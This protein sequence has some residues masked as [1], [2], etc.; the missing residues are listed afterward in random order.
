MIDHHAIH[1]AVRAHVLQTVVAT[2]TTGYERASSATYTDLNG[3]VQTAATDVLRDAHY[4]NGAGPQTLLESAATNLLTDS[5]DLSAAAWAGAG[6]MS[7]IGLITNSGTAPD[8]TLTADTVQRAAQ[9]VTLAP[10]TT[11]TLSAYIK[12]VDASVELFRVRNSISAAFL[13]PVLVTVGVS[14]T[15]TVPTLTI[16]DGNGTLAATEALADDWYR[17]GV[18]F[19][20]PATLAYNDIGLGNGARGTRFWGVELK[21]ESTRSSYVPSTGTPGTRAADVWELAATA[22]GYTSASGAFL[23]SG[24]RVGMEVQPSGFTQ[25]TPATITALSAGTM[26][27]KGG[28]T[29]Q[30]GATGRTIAVTLPAIRGYENVP[31]TPVADTPYCEEEYLPGGLTTQTLGNFGTLEAT[32]TYVLRL[33]GPQRTGMDALRRI[34]DAVITHCAPTT[35]IS[36]ANHTVRVRSDVAPTPS[37]LRLTDEGW[38]VITV[39]IPLRV[40]TANSR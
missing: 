16:T 36:V 26:T 23:A 32:P 18:T 11:Y 17:V 28:R 29:P 9:V 14:W 31:I 2:A 39:S 34:A 19:T 21:A 24:F 33:Y 35:P 38:A 15:G 13:G 5:E 6:V 20:T 1:L 10:S 3:V 8:G 40:H 37:A 7:R 30:V 25:T 4:V 22:T 12:R 27:V